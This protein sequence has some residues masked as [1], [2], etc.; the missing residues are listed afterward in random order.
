MKFFAS[1]DYL[2]DKLSQFILV[3]VVFL[4]LLL[5]VYSIAVRPM[6][7]SHIWLDPLLRHL[8]FLAVFLGG[9]LA[10]GKGNHIAIDI[11]G[12]VL[13]EKKLLVL[14]G[15][16]KGVVFL[17]CTLVT[18]WLA[19]VAVGVAQVEFQYGRKVFLGIHSGYLLSI[20]PLGFFIICY[21]FFYQFLK[22]LFENRKK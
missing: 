20:I 5:K 8:V 17:T 21:R 12:K 16:L 2:I 4:M 15:I 9:A 14:A 6:G 10:T 19:V 1:V 7:I 13:E 11:I 3:L 22:T 18:L